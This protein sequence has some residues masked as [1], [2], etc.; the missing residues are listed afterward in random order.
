MVS[1]LIGVKGGFV[2]SI[3]SRANLPSVDFLMP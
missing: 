3:V 1:I 2:N